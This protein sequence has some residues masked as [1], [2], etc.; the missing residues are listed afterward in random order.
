MGRSFPS[1]LS[2][3]KKGHAI[4]D[5]EGRIYPLRRCSVIYSFRASDSLGVRR[6]MP[7]FLIVALG[8][9]SIAWSQGW[10]C[11]NLCDA[12]SLKTLEYRWYWVGICSV[13]GL[14]AVLAA[15]PVLAVVLA[16]IARLSYLTK[17]WA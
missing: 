7:Q 17:L 9:R 12:S 6:Y 14:G 10:C 3:K 11:G 1:F 16:R 8:F 4:G 13:D 2:T 15:I 5:L